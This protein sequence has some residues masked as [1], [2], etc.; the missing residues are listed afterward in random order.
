MSRVGLLLFIFC[1]SVLVGSIEGYATGLGSIS[2]IAGLILGLL[3]ATM[4]FVFLCVIQCLCARWTKSKNDAANLVHV[5]GQV[6][7]AHGIDL[8]SSPQ[9]KKVQKGDPYYRV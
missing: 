1:L 8:K 4:F 6:E 5:S 7:G 3:V 9:I 2:G